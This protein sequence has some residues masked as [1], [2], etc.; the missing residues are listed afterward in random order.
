M[1]ALPFK[2]PKTGHPAILTQVDSGAYFYDILHKHP[3]Y[4][5]TLI[6]EGSGTLICDEYLGRFTPGDIIMFG[7]NQPHVLK[8]DEEFYKGAEDKR[9]HAIS[10]F[11]YGRCVRKWFSWTG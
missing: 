2:I 7:P 11:F 3:E 4:Q 8:C 9:V 1:K 5:I 6:L 10:F